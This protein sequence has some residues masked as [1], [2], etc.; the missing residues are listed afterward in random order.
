MCV[1]VVISEVLE[2][3]DNMLIR[4]VFHSSTSCLLTELLAETQ[5]CVFVTFRGRVG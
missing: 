1:C 5:L 4:P 2:F 3:V